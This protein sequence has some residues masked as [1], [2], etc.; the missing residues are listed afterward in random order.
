MTD[1]TPNTTRVDMP[2][3]AIS[4]GNA[5]SLECLLHRLGVD[6]S[7]LGTGGG[8]QH[9]QLF[10]DT[11]SPGKGVGAFDS[12][13]GGGATFA[14]SMTKLWDSKTDLSVFDIVILSCEGDQYPQTKP[15]TA[16]DALKGYADVGGRVF[17]SHWHNVWIEGSGN[18]KPAD[19]P[20]VANFNNDGTAF[21]G[22]QDRIDEGGNPKGNS[23]ATWMLNV[24][25]STT[26]DHI[27]IQGTS[28]NDATG[29]NTVASIT[30]MATDWVYWTGGTGMMPQNFQFETPVEGSADA[31]CGKVVFSDMHVSG[32]GGAGGS[33]P[34]SCGGATDLT[35]QEK[36]LAFMLFDIATCV[37]QIF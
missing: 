11:T 22:D 9:I 18:Q 14:D 32:N 21:F 15:Q 17:M 12:G 23:F 7:E 36:A 13:V 26:R 19:W 33:Y 4:T 37:G 28:Q 5:D 3:I 6:N 8:T 35:P 30:A 31:A 1:M 20:A 10:S 24:G 27:V 29:K 16:M 2:M 25:G 34:S